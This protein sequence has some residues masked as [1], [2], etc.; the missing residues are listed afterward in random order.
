MRHREKE[1]PEYATSTKGLRTT[2]IEGLSNAL[3]CSKTVQDLQ[4]LKIIIYIF[5]VLCYL[6]LL[7]KRKVGPLLN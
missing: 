7:R 4:Y 2:S 6:H 1:Y 3:I 5:K